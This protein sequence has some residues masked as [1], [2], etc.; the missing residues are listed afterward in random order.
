MGFLAPALPWLA[1]AAGIGTTAYDYSQQRGAQKMADV[2]RDD[3]VRRYEGN[4]TALETAK[5]EAADEL[6]RSYA[7][8]AAGVGSLYDDQGEAQKSRLN[9]GIDSPI[10][11]AID[12]NASKG[13][14]SAL[15]GL[16]SQR[17]AKSAANTTNFA[18]LLSSLA[19]PTESF[20]AQ[21]EGAG[22]GDVGAQAFQLGGGALYK[23]WMED[24]EKK[25]RA[26]L[27]GLSDDFLNL[28]AGLAN[29]AWKKSA[30]DLSG[31]KWDK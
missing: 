21:L 28:D 5:K 17:D 4:K 9:V 18:Q 19:Y 14:V 24:E 26:G 3:E 31:S 23:K 10:G 29:G 16:A 2:A 6:E 22:L 12:S 25:K 13:K 8:Q 7:N 27:S 15:S 30:P 1:A 20:D 11:R